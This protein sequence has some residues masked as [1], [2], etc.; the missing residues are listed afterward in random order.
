MSLS[1]LYSREEQKPIWP[2]ASASLPKTKARG[3][4]RAHLTYIISI[5]EVV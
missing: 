5:V 2:R 4:V 1:Y 3:H